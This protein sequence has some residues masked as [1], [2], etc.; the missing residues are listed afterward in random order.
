MEQCGN[1]G[2]YMLEFNI[3]LLC[4]AAASRCAQLLAAVFVNR[5]SPSQGQTLYKLIKI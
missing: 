5:T 2:V 1:N 4:S 3:P